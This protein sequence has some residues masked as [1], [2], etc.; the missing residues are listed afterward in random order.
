LGLALLLVACG[1]RAPAPAAIG[2]DLPDSPHTDGPQSPMVGSWRAEDGLVVELVERFGFVEAAKATDAAG[3]ALEVGDTMLRNERLFWTLELVDGT[4]LTYQ[5]VAL[6]GDVL[7]VRV[8]TGS[9][10]VVEVRLTR[11]VD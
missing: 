10:D 4:R 9:N 7:D 5:V 3:V 1:K 11:V 6:E 2:E 8:M